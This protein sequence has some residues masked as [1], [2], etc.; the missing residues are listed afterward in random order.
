MT[1]FQVGIIF[2]IFLLH[3]ICSSH[4]HVIETNDENPDIFPDARYPSTYRPSVSRTSEWLNGSP[5]VE[6]INSGGGFLN[7]Q[8]LMCNSPLGCVNLNLLNCGFDGIVN[9]SILVS[10]TMADGTKIVSDRATGTKI[11]EC[12]DSNTL[13]Y[14]PQLV[15]FP[16][17]NVA[18]KTSITGA[19]FRFSA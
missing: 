15:L 18:F 11:A 16:K 6:I 4:T 3:F 10:E 13:V 7:A 8:L 2:A 12:S 19:T 9:R 1:F 14:L 5:P 17:K